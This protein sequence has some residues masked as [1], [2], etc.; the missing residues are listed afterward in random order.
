MYALQVGG[1]D[2]EAGMVGWGIASNLSR[3]G[4]SSLPH[5]IAEGVPQGTA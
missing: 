2:V 5:Y 1:R 3:G 4:R